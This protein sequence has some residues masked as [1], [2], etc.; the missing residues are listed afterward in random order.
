M[1]MFDEFVGGERDPK[2]D[3]PAPPPPVA[4]APTTR[5]PALPDRRTIEAVP[6]TRLV[7]RPN[8]NVPATPGLFDEYAGGQPLRAPLA[9]GE[10]DWEAYN[11]PF[12]ELKVPDQSFTDYVKSKAQ[13][14]ILGISSALG[15]KPNSYMA[16]KI[17]SGGVDL[18]GFT[19]AGVVLSGGDAAHSFATG[20]PIRGGVE[21]LGAA[22]PGGQYIHRGEQA[23]RGTLPMMRMADTPTRVVD[24]ATGKVTDQLKNSSQAAYGR[25]S[26]APIDYHPGA[27]ENY[28]AWAQHHLQNTPGRTGS[29]F[30]PESAPGVFGVLNRFPAELEARGVTHVTPQDF[31]V[32]RRQ[33][34][35]FD[36]GPDSAAAA[37]SV[38]ILDN[39]MHNP[40]AGAVLR[41]EPGAMDRL[42]A[43]IASARG[44]WR[45]YKTA[46]RVEQEIDRRAVK[47]AKANSGLNLDNT[48]RQGLEQLIDPV[49]VGNR[50]PGATW[51]ER[52]LLQNVVTGD[53]PTNRMRYW[54]NR[55]GGGG[56]LTGSTV[57][58]VG[59]YGINHIL[60]AWGVDPVT[61]SALGAGLGYLTPKAGEALRVAS[62]ARTV[63][64]AEEAV[65]AIRRNSP[66]YRSREALA[67]DIP[68]PRSMQ[69]DAIA[70]A[71]AQPTVR[72]IE[73]FTNRANIP[74]ENR[75]EGESYAP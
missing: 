63:R 55:L 53:V 74:Y 38:E 56:G 73:G 65:D 15:G 32:L 36:Q 14:A 20:H 28:A 61:A 7:V 67:P 37:R 33:L 43:D 31:D 21:T 1:G 62:G 29:V 23:I 24:Q 54:S 30:T 44:D 59:A 39:Y 4:P 41:M 52:Q 26:Q 60:G 27:I 17:A 25:V 58:G 10:T 70:Y 64:Q 69:R 47:T 19:P 51:S 11:K 50:L 6:D 2:Y 35:S 42:R 34:R 48:T 40:P 13:D 49:H 57:G 68:D 66:L 16:G 46:D 12:G 8:Q 5:G 9:K 18:A 75:D 72:T 22:L 71:M 3:P 45:A